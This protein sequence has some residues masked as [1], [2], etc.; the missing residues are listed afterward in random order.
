[1]NAYLSEIDF[2]EVGTLEPGHIMTDSPRQWRP[3]CQAGQ[4]KIGSTTTGHRNG[5]GPNP[6]G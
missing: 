2:E 1:M 5:G 4:F 3:D 6:L